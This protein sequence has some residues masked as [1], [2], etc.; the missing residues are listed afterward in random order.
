VDAR[1]ASVLLALALLAAPPARAASD[2]CPILAKGR[3][4]DPATWP[5]TGVPKAGACVTIPA[6]RTVWL[7]VSPPP[8]GGLVVEGELVFTCT[9]LELT[10][11]RILVT[12]LLAAGSDEHAFHRRAT[13]TLT[14]R[15][16][17]SPERRTLAVEHSGH[18][19]LV[20]RA[21]RPS[22]TRLAE[23]APKGALEL[24][25]ERAPF[26][27]VGQQLVVAS[28]D[29]AA[30]QAEVRTIA[31]VSGAKVGLAA[32]LEHTHWGAVEGRDVDGVGVE[33]R[34]EVGLLS[35]SI[36]VRGEA[37]PVPGAPT[38]AGHTILRHPRGP[39]SAPRAELAWVEFTNLGNEGQLGRYPLHF[40]Q[41][42]DALGSYVESC[43][44]HDTHNRA[45]SVHTTQNLRVEGNVAFANV[46]H[47]FYMEDDPAIGCTLRENLGLLTR[48]A[49]FPLLPSDAAPATFWLHNPANV[50]EDNAAAGSDGF[51]FWFAVE[52]GETTAPTSFRGN[53]AHSNADS[54]F[55]GDQRPQPESTAWYRDLVAWKNRRYGLWLRSF[56]ASRIENF[57]GADNRGGIYVASEGFQFDLADYATGAHRLGR[58]RTVVTRSLLI[59]ESDNLG[60]AT[61][62]IEWKVGRSLPQRW[63]NAPESFRPPWDAL[64]GVEI[65]DGLLG[66]EDT[67]FAHYRERDVATSAC[68]N[69]SFVRAAG[70]LAHVWYD[71]PWAVDP[72][73][74]VRGLAFVDAQRV[75][76][77]TPLG[78]HTLSCGP[79]VTD[80]GLSNTILQ[81]LDGS[82]TG[83]ARSVVFAD[84]PFL[85]P[86]SGAS[87]DPGWNAFVT[88]GPPSAPFAQLELY[89]LNELVGLPAAAAL[90]FRSKSSGATFR[91][92]GPLSADCPAPVRIPRYHA[93]VVTGETYELLYDAGVPSE[94]WARVLALTLQFTEPG[95]SV[96]VSLPI[97]PPTTSALVEVNGKPAPLA[98]DLGTLLAGPAN[99][100]F[101]DAA[102]QTLWVKIECE[103]AGRSRTLF[104]GLR[105]TFVVVSL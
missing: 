25:L 33:V 16:G 103:A 80:A 9:D 87:F 11:D 95:R 46:G 18:L 68:P 15:F 49:P 101:Y 60:E 2:A 8:L 37:V 53:V 44:V 76:L 42:G 23:T 20:G 32:P 36:V 64:T 100:C 89:N 82:L 105:T 27:E 22:W 88:A 19:R 74:Y 65:Y 13:I 43:S 66:I 12:G 85:M 48:A 75:H 83:I 96:V 29:F 55:Y 47:A 17:C 28:S 91:C 6:G 38:L 58:A 35:R 104:E 59:G 86:P 73:N 77:R 4:S 3:W 81:D 70:A 79:K 99:A 94:R 61:S 14:D 62:C 67:A 72:R 57:R 30:S 84:N 97:L 7:D 26:W 51:G 10:S 69:K 5:A 78:V 39:G 50:V 54:G 40:H 90:T 63:S 1:R 24:V 45:L 71:S 98:P 31:S 92:Y 52:D 21:L 56:G 41:I 34:A 93:N 102:A